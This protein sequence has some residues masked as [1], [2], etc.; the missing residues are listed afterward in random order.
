MDRIHLPAIVKLRAPFEG[1][2]GLAQKDITTEDAATRI[3]NRT[4]VRKG[5]KFDKTTGV[6]LDHQETAITRKIG[7]LAEKQRRLSTKFTV[8]GGK[9][10]SNSRSEC[11]HPRIRRTDAAIGLPNISLTIG[12]SASRNNSDAESRTTAKKAKRCRVRHAGD[13]ISYVYSKSLK[14]ENCMA[15]LR[16]CNTEFDKGVRSEQRSSESDCGVID[17]KKP[18]GLPSLKAN[19]EC[20]ADHDRREWVT[21]IGQGSLA[22]GESLSNRWEVDDGVSNTTNYDSSDSL[23]DD[24]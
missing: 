13:T 16:N 8:S 1:G 7:I 4:R 19:V 3:T 6:N 24:E 5:A 18:Y 15:F 23:A 9:I 2:R 11:K 12:G 22:N 17:T 10:K 20:I 14:D 21:T